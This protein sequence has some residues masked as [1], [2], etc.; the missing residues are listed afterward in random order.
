MSLA[1]SCPRLAAR[2]ALARPLNRCSSSMAAPNW[3]PWPQRQQTQRAVAATARNRLADLLADMREEEKV[4]ETASS[5][6][7]GAPPTF[8]AAPPPPPA[9][10][11]CL[12]EPP[13]LRCA[14]CP[15]YT[16][17]HPPLAVWFDPPTL[18]PL[19]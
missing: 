10:A 15:L 16:T 14:R 6:P 7:E 5:V 17:R 13:P 11:A 12:L 8:A 9:A 1:A 2:A 19:Q 18:L 4:E 3:A